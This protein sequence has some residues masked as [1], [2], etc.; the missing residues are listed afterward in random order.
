MVPFMVSPGEI[1]MA[2]FVTPPGIL[3]VLEF[4]G[5]V[6]RVTRLGE[7]VI[8]NAQTL[9]WKSSKFLGGPT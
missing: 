5:E 9:S 3:K 8:A 7:D 6:C 4:V 1:G 2:S